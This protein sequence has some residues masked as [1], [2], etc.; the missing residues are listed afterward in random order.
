M[1]LLFNYIDLSFPFQLFPTSEDM[2]II[3]D[4]A[5]NTHAKYLHS[6]RMHYDKKSSLNP[7]HS[8]RLIDVFRYC[9]RKDPYLAKQLD[10]EPAGFD[11]TQNMENTQSET[12]TAIAPQPSSMEVDTQSNLDKLV[13]KNPAVSEEEQTLDNIK[14]GGQSI[15]AQFADWQAA[16]P[17]Y[18]FHE[19]RNELCGDAK[20]K[21][22]ASNLFLYGLCYTAT[23]AKKQ[24]IER[25]IE[26]KD[27]DYSRHP[28][29]LE[30]LIAVDNESHDVFNFQKSMSIDAINNETRAIDRKAHM[31][32]EIPLIDSEICKF[33]ESISTSG[34]AKRKLMMPA[35]TKVAKAFNAIKKQET[36]E[37][38]TLE[39]SFVESIFM[40]YKLRKKIEKAKAECIAFNNIRMYS[41][42]F[43]DFVF[44]RSMNFRSTYLETLAEGKNKE[45]NTKARKM[46]AEY[47]L[48]VLF[49][50]YNTLLFNCEKSF[51]KI[52]NFR[53]FDEIM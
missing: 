33:M 10:Q 1:E 35:D 15:L 44:Y 26:L 9:I 38:T 51:N 5:F 31:F 22:D 48:E 34:N 28:T 20:I 11:N 29:N 18:S 37:N 49:L 46:A 42:N 7:E 27:V 2:P 32:W 8:E 50:Q 30:E 23:E 39:L 13:S 3:T 52:I 17:S 4:E 40:M 45:L 16:G 53:L 21:F 24:W 12:N 47:Y 14:G 36:E 43:G 6:L 25:T 41:H 19:L